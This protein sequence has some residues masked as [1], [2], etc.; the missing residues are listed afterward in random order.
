MLELYS[1]KRAK[2]L[3]VSSEYF[4][5]SIPPKVTDICHFIPTGFS[6][7]FKQQGRS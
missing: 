4:K 3:L 7:V 6:V 2:C 1:F 5:D